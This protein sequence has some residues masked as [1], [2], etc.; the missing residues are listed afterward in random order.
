MMSII[1]YLFVIVAFFIRKPDIRLSK[2]MVSHVP[3]KPDTA[4]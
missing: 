3:R 2:S 1:N 4:P